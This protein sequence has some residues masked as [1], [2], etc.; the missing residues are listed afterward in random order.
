MPDP[1]TRPLIV[2][3]RTG[4]CSFVIRRVRR[5]TGARDTCGRKH[6]IHLPLHHMTSSCVIGNAVC[7]RRGE[8]KIRITTHPE[9]V[10]YH[11]LRSCASTASRE[12]IE[13]GEE[14]WGRLT[15]LNKQLLEREFGTILFKFC[16]EVIFSHIAFGEI[17]RVTRCTRHP[18][19]VTRC[20][21]LAEKTCIRFSTPS[22]RL[23]KVCALLQTL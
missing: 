18:L 3:N 20:P 11:P 12:S 5:A 22:F 15:E 1:P 8:T 6:L 16:F 7:T 10:F 21:S 14:N 4:L 23:S 13:I 19:P 2:G 17:V 9:P